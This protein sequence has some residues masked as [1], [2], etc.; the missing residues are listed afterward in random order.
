MVAFVLLAGMAFAEE[1]EQPKYPEVRLSGVIYPS[2][3]LDLTAGSNFANAFDVSRVYLRTDVAINKRFATRVTLDADHMRPAV[4]ATGE[5]VTYD[6]KYRVFVKHAYLEVRELGPLRLRA[7]VIDTPYTPYYDNLW[8][9]RYITESFAKNAGVLET[10]DLGVALVGQ[11]A[12]GLVDWN[13]SLLNGE[14]YSKLEVDAGKTAQARFTIDPL[15]K[16]KERALP[17]T[18]FVSYAGHPTTGE[19]TLTWAGAA[20]FEMPRLLV[21]GELLGTTTAGTTGMGYSATLNPRL[22][23]YLGVIGRFDHWDPNTSARDD[24][25][26]LLIAG[27]D[28]DFSDRISVALTYERE[29][30]DGAAGAA[31]H[32]VVVHTQAGF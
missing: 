2:Y 16:P 29:W 31:T 5:S 25:E 21:W 18:G 27:L 3:S 14:G 9:N 19:P 4:L 7:G 28:K 1:K 22:P 26:N 13:V 6:T 17:I 11:H 8:G 12:E 20:G 15:A 10:A 24:G 32:G 30:V 23:K